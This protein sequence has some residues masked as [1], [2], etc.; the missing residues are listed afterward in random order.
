MKNTLLR[1]MI[2]IALRSIRS[3][4][5]RTSLTIAVIGLGITALISMTTA[6]SSLEANV[7][8]QFS[9]LGTNVFSISRKSEG[10]ISQGTRV[11]LGEPISYREARKFTELAPEELMVS[12]SVFGTQQATVGRG[13]KQTNPNIAVLGIDA[14]YLDV[15]G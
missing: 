14:N 3:N 4:L 12:Y 10:G 9:S 8:K 13:G 5:L 1:E 7:E 15:S 11:N 2:L 6:T